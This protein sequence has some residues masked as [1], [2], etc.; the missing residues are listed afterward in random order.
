MRRRGVCDGD[1]NGDG[2]VFAMAMRAATEMAMPAFLR[3]GDAV[4]LIAPS[5]APRPGALEPAVESVRALGL[6][7]KAYPSCTLEHGYLA[8]TD[9]QRARDVNDAFAD[10]EARG[11]VCVRGG[12]GAHRLMGRIH[13]DAAVE[14]R[15]PLYGYSDVTALH[16]ELNR[17][18]LITWHTP[19]PA[20]EW[21]KNPGEYTMGYLRAALFG[22]LPARIENPPAVPLE[23]LAPG[24]AEGVLCGGNL[25]LVAATLGTPY[26]LD[27]KGKILFLEDIGE[28]PYRLDRMLLQLKH[29]G[30]FD[31]CA[32]V[33]L[34]PFTDSVPDNTLP[35]LTVAQVLAEILGD[36]GRPVLAG[37]QCGHVL[38]TAS[39]PLGMRVSLDATAQTI[40]LS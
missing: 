16:L 35:T 8:G 4:A 18:G 33:L 9:E 40:R 21:R 11:V 17:R 22:P 10:P 38:P 20:T 32:G 28:I 14:S 7:P 1:E 24:R 5:S 6:V 25:S 27:A 12:Y 29:A 26:E 31:D 13:W 37:L 23:T 30:K 3:E 2:G 34:G 36:I 19:M 15:K 39:L